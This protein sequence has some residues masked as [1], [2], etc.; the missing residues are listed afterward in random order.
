MPA[1][2]PPKKI[3]MAAAL[4]AIVGKHAGGQHAAC[5]E[6]I[7]AEMPVMKRTTAMT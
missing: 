4:R 2:P 6:D 5:H 1:P 3:A 7:G